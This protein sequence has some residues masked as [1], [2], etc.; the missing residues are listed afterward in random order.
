MANLHQKGTSMKLQTQPTQDQVKEFVLAA[1]A[2]FDKVKALLTADPH[3]LNQRYVDF[4]E[5]A[6]EAASH[7]GNRQ[8]AEY[9]LDA[10]APLTI[11]A[12]AMLG[13]MDDVAEIV[14]KDPGLVNAKGAHGIP[15][16]YH[17]ALSGDTEL[18]ELLL[19]LGGGA[20]LETSL[21]AAVKFG[22]S[23]MTRWLLAHGAAREVKDFQERTPLQV[24]SENG[25]QEIVALLTP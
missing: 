4:N 24:A 1:H 9:L 10:G 3:L 8:I 13:R 7:M 25:F 22:H 23:E 18:T 16:I 17:A 20:G 14:D 2:D 5:T 19:A 15:L 21:H 6:L 12:A 11:C